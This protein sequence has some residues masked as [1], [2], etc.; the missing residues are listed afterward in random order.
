MIGINLHSCVIS[1]LN[2]AAHILTGFLSLLLQA[3]TSQRWL[4]WWQLAASGSSEHC[5]LPASRNVIPALQAIEDLLPARPSTGK[6]TPR[7]F[8][9]LCTRLICPGQG[10]ASLK[11]LKNEGV[12][13]P[14]VY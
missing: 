4:A 14:H 10:R 13:G 1:A 6:T 2:A 3:D 12:Q 5:K 9:S 7:I 11:S 8:L